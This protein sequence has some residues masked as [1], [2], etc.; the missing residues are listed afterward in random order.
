MLKLTL[1]TPPGADAYFDEDGGT[2]GRAPAN[3][4]VLSGDSNISQVHLAIE[5]LQD[6]WVLKDLGDLLPVFHNGKPLGYGSRA[7]LSHGD[8]VR[9]SGMELAVD[10]H[11]SRPAAATVPA[12]A[13]APV[14][15]A[16][17]PIVVAS[18]ASTTVDPFDFGTL[19]PAAPAVNKPMVEPAAVQ[20]TPPTSPAATSGSSVDPFDFGDLHASKPVASPAPVPAYVAPTAAA[21]ASKPSS[22]DPFDFGDLT[23]P[24]QRINQP[25]PPPSHSYTGLDGLNTNTTP[26]IAPNTAALNDRGGSL[27]SMLGVGTPAS[28]LTPVASTADSLDLLFGLQAG[29]SAD[30]LAPGGIFDRYNQP[31]DAFLDLGTP[32]APSVTQADHTPGIHSS[33]RLHG[34]AASPTIPMDDTISLP[35]PIVPDALPIEPAASLAELEKTVEASPPVVPATP[36]AAPAAAP[37]ADSL[38]ALFGLDKP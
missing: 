33:V 4:L 29:S 17:A 24:S 35:A 5:K 20:S 13:M 22:I 19:Q 10:L 11:A 8:S 14:A 16:V 6:N 2:V 7:N 38:D 30:P 21:P 32:A 23:P 15:A 25:A 26:V 34:S 27:G 36:P 37:A 9:I 31:S 3:H 28:S 18:T 12:V 1:L